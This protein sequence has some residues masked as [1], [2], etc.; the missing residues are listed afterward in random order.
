MQSQGKLKENIDL[1]IYTEL[2]IFKIEILQWWKL[3]FQAFKISLEMN[4]KIF[5]NNRVQGR[6][7]TGVFSSLIFVYYSEHYLAT[8]LQLS[9]TTLCLKRKKK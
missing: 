6:G 2:P 5:I 8:K 4:C 3:L 9:S 1:K 7:I